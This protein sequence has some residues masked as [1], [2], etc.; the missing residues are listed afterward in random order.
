[1]L[2]RSSLRF[3]HRRNPFIRYLSVMPV[4]RRDLILRHVDLVSN[5]STLNSLLEA[6]KP[7]SVLWCPPSTQREF[8]HIHLATLCSPPVLVLT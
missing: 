3:L 1:M 2:L 5:A 4:D 6:N 8:L 7:V